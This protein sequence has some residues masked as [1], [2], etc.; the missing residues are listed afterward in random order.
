MIDKFALSVASLDNYQQEG[1]GAEEP[2]VVIVSYGE[3][4]RIAE[5]LASTPWDLVA[6]DEAHQLANA[7]LSDH[8]QADALRTAL[9]GRRK[10]LFTATPMQNSMMNLIPPHLMC[11][12]VGGHAARV[13]DQ[14]AR[15]EAP[16]SSNVTGDTYPK[17]AWRR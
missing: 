2:K 10:L 12:T 8:A 5:R 17:L 7:G 3:A 14:A 6:L 9:K 13:K 11:P 16:P 1:N 4:H 15:I